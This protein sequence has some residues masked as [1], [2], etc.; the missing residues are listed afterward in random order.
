V[1]GTY[2][3]LVPVRRRVR[4]VM[5]IILSRNRKNFGPGRIFVNRSAGLFWVFILIRYICPVPCCSETEYCDILCELTWSFD[6]LWAPGHS[7][8]RKLNHNKGLSTAHVHF[9]P[10]GPLHK[11]PRPRAS[12]KFRCKCRRRPCIRLPSST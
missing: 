9:Y 4:C 7:E 11:M 5:F 1:S 3:V 6:E 8:P 2:P 12:R 10:F